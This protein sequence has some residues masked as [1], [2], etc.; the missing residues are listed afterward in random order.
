MTGK[1]ETDVIRRVFAEDSKGACIEIGPWPD[2]PAFL[3]LRAAS[4][5]SKR[6]FGPINLSM[7]PDFAEALGKALLDAAKDSRL[8]R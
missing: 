4:D 1:V 3:E 8:P 2:D 6:W 5:D 7:S